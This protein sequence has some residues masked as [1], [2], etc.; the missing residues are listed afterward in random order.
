MVTLSE[1]VNALVFDHYDATHNPA[2][3]KRTFDSNLDSDRAGVLTYLGTYFPRSLA[4]TFVIFDSLLSDKSLASSLACEPSINICSVGTG[5]GGDLLGLILAISK[6]IPNAM[7][8]N[9]VSIE[10]NAEAHKV[11][12]GVIGEAQTRVG[13]NIDL[14]SVN[15]VFEA[16]KP[17]DRIRDILPQYPQSF[18]FV[19][20]S[21]MLNELD[22]AHV[23]EQP[24]REFCSAFT[25]TLKPTGM[26]M[27]LDVTS[28]NGAGGRWTP[29]LLNGQVNEFLAGNARYKTVLPLLCNRFEGECGRSCYTQNAIY[30]NYRSVA[31]ECSKICYRVIGSA[32]L[33]EKLS[34]SVAL[35]NCPIT[36]DNRTHCQE[37]NEID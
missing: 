34:G 14:N 10:G 16:P 20:N 31:N 8:L 35:W 7:Q 23:S 12:R 33:A 3:R 17:F 2:G 6:W 18:D 28:P 22:K 15:H 27:V 24:Y 25:A 13:I 32:E 5:T 30:V 36:E 1:W 37:F 9:I 26:L 11:M 21:K 29:A 4:E 19:I